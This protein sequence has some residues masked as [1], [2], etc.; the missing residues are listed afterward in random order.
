MRKYP[1]GMVL[2]GYYSWG[3]GTSP[4]NQGTSG[5]YWSS[6]AYTSATSAYRL[7]LYGTNSTVYPANDNSKRSGFSLRCLAQ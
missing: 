1:V 6:S 5:Y 4:Y 7:Y 2:G 3:N